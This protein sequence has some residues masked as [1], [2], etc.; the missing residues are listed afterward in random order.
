MRR[1]ELLS[2]IASAPSVQARDAHARA[3]HAIEVLDSRRRAPRLGDALEGEHLGV[4]A[5]RA[6]ESPTVIP[7]ESTALL[8]V[9][10]S[11]VRIATTATS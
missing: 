6:V 9:A 3:E 8:A 4:E 11:A 1:E 2:S 10:L 7:T 5:H